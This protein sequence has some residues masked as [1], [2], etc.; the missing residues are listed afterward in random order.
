MIP[1]NLQI[2]TRLETDY[3]NIMCDGELDCLMPRM[4]KDL[5]KGLSDE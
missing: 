5:I 3:S 4:V 2:R 1:M